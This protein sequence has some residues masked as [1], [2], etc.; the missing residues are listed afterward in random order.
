MHRRVRVAAALVALG[1]VTALTVAC[2]TVLGLD[3]VGY[4][5]DA[6][7]GSNDATADAS[8]GAAAGDAGGGDAAPTGCGP[9]T[10]VCIVCVPERR[11]PTGCAPKSCESCRVGPHADAG[12][13]GTQ[14]VIAGCQAPFHDCDHVPAN[15]CE[16]DTTRGDPANCGGCGRTCDA[17]LL[18]QPDGGCALKCDAPRVACDGGCIDTNGDTQNCLGCGNVCPGFGAP[19][20]LVRCVATGCQSEC[21]AGYY[22]CNGNA[23]DGC[24]CPTASGCDAGVCQDCTTFLQGGCNTLGCCQYDYAAPSC[25]GD[26]CCVATGGAC[27]DNGWCCSGS[28]LFQGLCAP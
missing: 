15:G 14:C 16:T 6:G 9:R 2:A 21:A 7:A 17:G 24:E 26:R 5:A 13:S 20:M 25:N 11:V 3:D 28:C 10:K 27:G 23:A 19:Q 22:D 12:C 8:D 18:C 4:G 1:G